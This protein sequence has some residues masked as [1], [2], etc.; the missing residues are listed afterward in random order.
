[1]INFARY[2]TTKNYK[3]KDPLEEYIKS[4]SWASFYIQD[5]TRETKSL[6]DFFF[7]DRRVCNICL[8]SNRDDGILV[9]V[10]G[11]EYFERIKKDLESY[12]SQT[13]ENINLFLD[14]ENPE[15]DY[16]NRYEFI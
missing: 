8:V 6:F 5:P 2:L 3:L 9:R 13:K 16:P 10:W 15:F 1:M 11:R 4:D 7:Q 14:K 12:C